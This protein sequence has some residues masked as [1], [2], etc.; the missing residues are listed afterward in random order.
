MI[1]C[2]Q[3]VEAGRLA[4]SCKVGHEMPDLVIR[5]NGAPNRWGLGLGQ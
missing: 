5:R 4:N 1:A 2:M 3:S